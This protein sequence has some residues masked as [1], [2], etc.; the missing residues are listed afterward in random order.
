MPWPTPPT[1]TGRFVSSFYK[2]VRCSKGQG[3]F[4]C[5]PCPFV[6]HSPKEHWFDISPHHIENDRRTGEEKALLKYNKKVIF[7]HK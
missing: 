5:H 4:C 1:A 7:S 2:I 6:L 3:W